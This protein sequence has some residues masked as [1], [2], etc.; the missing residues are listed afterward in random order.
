MKID[1]RSEN[2]VYIEMNGKTFYIDDSTDEQIMDCWK[3]NSRWSGEGRSMGLED[4]TKKL[5]PFNMS[6]LKS[7]IKSTLKIEKQIYKD[8]NFEDKNIQG[9]IEGLE[10][11]LREIKAEEVV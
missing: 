2:C 8:G 4:N 10:Y 1:V 11:V 3:D 7:Q 6:Y 5:L 9:W